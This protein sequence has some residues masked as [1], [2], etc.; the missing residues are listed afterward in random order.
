[1]ARAV[2]IRD[3]VRYPYTREAFLR[4]EGLQKLPGNR[5]IPW[6]LS[7]RASAVRL[8]W[9]VHAWACQTRRP[10]RERRRPSGLVPISDLGDRASRP[11]VEEQ[12]VQNM[13]VHDFDALAQGDKD[14]SR[15]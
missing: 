14:R 13:R 7:D 10:P 1:M 12:Y 4:G 8:N 2:Q 3:V 11:E 6:R 5:T 15:T 9:E